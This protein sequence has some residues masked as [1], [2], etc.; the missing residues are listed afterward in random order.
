MLWGQK[1][2]EGFTPTKAGTAD[3]IRSQHE[4]VTEAL[5]SDIFEFRS[6]EQTYGMIAALHDVMATGGEI[7][8]KVPDAAARLSL[9]DDSPI[10]DIEKITGNVQGKFMGLYNEKF[11]S[12]AMHAA[13]FKH[14]DVLKGD[15][16]ML[17]VKGK[18]E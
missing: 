14:V 11:M 4:G 5:V 17:I 13:G 16:D 18:K 2:V 12:D 1:D 6:N 15:G 8:I 3:D 7:T 9:S 10:E